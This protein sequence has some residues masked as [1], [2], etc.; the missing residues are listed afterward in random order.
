MQMQTPLKELI[1]QPM[2]KH[3]TNLP[4]PGLLSVAD[5]TTWEEKQIWPIP[6]SAYKKPK[7]NLIVV[8]EYRLLELIKELRHVLIDTSEPAKCYAGSYMD[9]P[10]IDMD[11][12][13]EYI[14]SD[15]DKMTA[16]EISP[17][18]SV[19][20]Y[21]LMEVLD[22]DA[23]FTPLLKGVTD[24]VQEIFQILTRH[25]LEHPLDHHAPHRYELHQ[26]L[27]SGG[28]VLRRVDL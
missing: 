14:C 22:H 19:N 7:D 1:A 6:D 3:I 13:L 27:P 4:I 10:V 16:G 24:I 26:I 12:M 20:R 21:V 17:S 18:H 11:A 23:E 5:F 28:L 9:I 25:V 2:F 8:R 15:L